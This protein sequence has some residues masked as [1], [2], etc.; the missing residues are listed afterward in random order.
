MR[1]HRLPTVR[2]LAIPAAEPTTRQTA[3]MEPT[4]KTKTRRSGVQRSAG[5]RSMARE[6]AARESAKHHRRPTAHQRPTDEA[7]PRTPPTVDPGP[8][9]RAT[10]E[11]KPT[12]RAILK[13]ALMNQP[14]ATPNAGEHRPPVRRFAKR[15]GPPTA[16]QRPPIEPKAKAKAAVEAKPALGAGPAIE[17]TTA[18]EGTASARARSAETLARPAMGANLKRDGGP[19][20]R[21]ILM[22][23]GAPAQR[24]TNVR[25]TNPSDTTPSATSLREMSPRAK[26][27]QEIR[28]RATSQ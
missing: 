18:A 1:H 12:T 13:A 24:T 17:T 6:S 9:A 28:L 7:R 16:R 22:P 15:H 21:S 10:V 2:Q 19:E 23:N 4:L 26:N 11:A 3:E 25:E 27:P 5:R 8:P 14:T 20:T